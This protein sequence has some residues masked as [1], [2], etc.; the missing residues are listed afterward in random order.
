MTEEQLK[1][2]LSPKVFEL[3]QKQTYQLTDEEKLAIQTELSTIEE[4]LQTA[5][6]KSQGR[7][8]NY[9]HPRIMLDNYVDYSLCESITVLNYRENNFAGTFISLRLSL[10]EIKDLIE[11]LQNFQNASIL[12][13]AAKKM[14]E[15]LNPRRY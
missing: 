4:Q 14:K 1:G 7:M 9:Q 13:E 5:R 10:D 11:T 6:E 15:H 3:L 2:L 8:G 12:F